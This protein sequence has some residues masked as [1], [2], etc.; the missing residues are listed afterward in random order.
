MILLHFNY[1]KEASNYEN[2]RKKKSLAIVI[3]VVMIAGLSIGFAALSETL[4]INGTGE[5]KSSNW[6]VHFEN[7]AFGNGNGNTKVIT[8]PTLSPTK[9]GDYSV[10]F[11]SPNDGIGLSFDIVNAGSYS[12]NVAVTIPPPICTGTGSNAEEDAKNVCDYLKYETW[13]IH[14]GHVYDLQQFLDGHDGIF[15]LSAGGKVTIIINL[16]YDK[17]SEMTPDLLPKNDVVVSNLEIPMIAT[18]R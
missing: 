3:L 18:Q 16:I 5:V 2:E 7:L 14:S 11:K 4:T 8:E 15:P 12:A 1:I 6:D 9:I 10:E 13:V 17:N